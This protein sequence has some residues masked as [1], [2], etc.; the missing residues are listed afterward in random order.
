MLKNKIRQKII[1]IRKK[2]FNKSLN[3]K[4]NKILEIIKKSNKY[5][6][7]IGGYYPINYE[8]DCLKILKSL[9]INN[10]KISL[11]I[12]SKYNSME[13][14]KYSF[15]QPLKLNKYGIPEPNK[16]NKILPDILLVPLVAFDKN[17]F[18]IGYGAGYYDR[19]ITKL[20]KK[21]S[22]ITIGLAFSFQL[23]KKVPVNKFD[24][25]LDFIIT[26]NKVYK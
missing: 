13:F 17:L 26:E 3:I 18:R 15:N 16:L 12:I 20:E 21:K 1:V 14:Y 4:I 5:K 8:I 23:V 6:P 24:K 2:K 19:Y 9:E 25:K 22:F 10:F 7:L 11:P